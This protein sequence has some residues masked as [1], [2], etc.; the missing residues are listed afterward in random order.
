MLRAVRPTSSLMGLMSA[1]YESSGR[2]VARSPAVPGTL[3]MRR[4]P[5]AA[6]SLYRIREGPASLSNVFDVVLHFHQHRIGFL[7]QLCFLAV[8]RPPVLAQIAHAERSHEDMECRCKL[9]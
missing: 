8:E 1:S 2:L 7:A 3:S 9:G 5:R 6:R 4:M